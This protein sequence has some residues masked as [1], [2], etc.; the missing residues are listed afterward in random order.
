MQIKLKSG[1]VLLI[2]GPISLDQQ[3]LFILFG[4]VIAT[5]IANIILGSIALI[6]GFIMS[7]IILRNVLIAKGH[8][9]RKK[10]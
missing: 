2:I 5:L 9:V 8:L 3:D 6:F 4:L 1:P 7:G 10:Q